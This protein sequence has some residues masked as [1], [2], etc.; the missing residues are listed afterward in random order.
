MRYDAILFD[1]DGVLIEPPDRETL[2]AAARRTFRECGVDDPSEEHVEGLV[3]GVDLDWLADV[4]D[5]YDVEREPFW[6]RR[7][8]CSSRAQREAIAAGETTAYDDVAVLERIAAPVGIVSTNQHETIEFALEHFDLADHVDAFY[9]REPT[10]DGLR[11]KKP[12]P[13]YLRR[14]LADLE[15]DDALFVGDSE[16]DVRAARNAGLDSAF[17]RRPHRRETTLSVEPTY[18]FETLRALA[19]ELDVVADPRST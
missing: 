8:E 9:G 5:A 3:S 16:S 2:R 7:D 19:D 11:R 14:I 18:E 10:I 1:N 4:C 13:Y 17:L 12:N 15:A 6:R